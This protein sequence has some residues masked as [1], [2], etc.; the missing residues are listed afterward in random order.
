MSV[1]LG[2]IGE[3]IAAAC[4]LSLGWRVSMCQ[5]NSIDLLAFD[6]DT[7][8]RIQ[9]KASMP[10]VSNRRRSPSCHFQLGLGGKKRCATI[11][12]YDIV[13]LVQPQSRLCLFMPVTSVLQYKTKRV[14]P[15][16]FT[17]ENEADS[18]HKAV[19]SI[20]EMRQLNGLVKVS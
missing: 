11:E 12:D 2:L 4:I 16:R 20:L 17:A 13:A 5:Q 3:H 18:W 19:D 10:Y 6:N 15:S 8:L 14:S 1:T 7:F 9:C